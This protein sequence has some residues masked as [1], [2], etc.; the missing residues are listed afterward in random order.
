MKIGD[1]KPGSAAVIKERT[2]KLSLWIGMF[3][4][5]Y[6]TS[7]AAVFGG[8]SPFG[9][10]LI[11]ACPQSGILGAAGGVLL[12]AVLPLAGGMQSKYLIAA[13]LVTA[14][15]LLAGN[16]RNRKAGLV[17]PI[18]ALSS[19]LVPAVVL[20]FLNEL[21]LSSVLLA[22]SESLLA[23]AGTYFFWTTLQALSKGRS[24]GSLSR[25]ET[26]SGIMTLAILAAALCNVQAGIISAGRIIITAILVCLA[27]SFQEAGGALSGVIAGAVVISVD[28]TFAP[29]LGIY[30]F[31]S[32]IAGLFGRLSRLLCMISFFLVG[33]AVCLITQNENWL[34][35]VLELAAGCALFML[36]P[37]R[38][39][40]ALEKTSDQDFNESTLKSIVK[41]RLSVL[42]GV[43]TDVSDTITNVA[44]HAD[45]PMAGEISTVYDRTAERI[46]KRCGL[47]LYCYDVAFNDTAGIFN[48]FTDTLKKK[49]SL[50]KE[51]VPDFFRD[52]CCKLSE[53][54]SEINKNYTEFL[55]AAK[56]RMKSVQSRE[57][58][59]DHLHGMSRLLGDLSEEIERIKTSDS[60]VCRIA[61]RYF[62]SK[63]V[64]IKRIDCVVDECGRLTLTCELYSIDGLSLKTVS[65]DLSEM[66]GRFFDAPCVM[67]NRDSILLSL[68]EKASFICDM[69]F[70]QIPFGGSKYCGDAC[71][72]F[73]DDKGNSYVILSDGM[74]SGTKAAID[75]HMA[76]SLLSRLI[77]AGFGFE[78]AL[79]VVNASLITK[80]GE[81]SLST[82]DALKVDLFTGKGRLLKAGAAPTFVK[83]NNRVFRVEAGSLP[84]GIIGN[85]RF[86]ERPLSLR[87][88]DIVLMVSD[89]VTQMGNEWIELELSAC[90][91]AT[92]QELSK[93]IANAAKDHI[94]QSGHDDDI[95]AVAVY[96][97]KGS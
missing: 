23:A 47:R 45:S 57:M 4:I 61:G 66:C 49:G 91:F 89:G 70:F 42:S 30:S 63:G 14:L 11:A 7:G 76:C 71:N 51:D 60:S 33:S 48:G 41:N 87:Y 25:I 53:L 59:T 68:F 75:G 8:L 21:S 80:P 29:L 85:I 37:E 36:V 50:G 3:F 26:Y 54:T 65:S 22:L 10:S 46:C 84:V 15:K 17:N 83:R 5:G 79:G 64:K 9:I 58:V 12:G 19:V 38:Y 39:L 34:M 16:D 88:G 62:D 92:P 73:L 20:N 77:K 32:M 96:V 18:L 93:H 78:A 13:A 56:L 2:D 81:E 35:I 28:P 90:A 52:R 86:E 27:Y 24:L 1:V 6:V 97:S 72:V 31:S 40:K 44:K 43:L 74:G 55:A 82:L 67:H 94:G 95:T 69:G